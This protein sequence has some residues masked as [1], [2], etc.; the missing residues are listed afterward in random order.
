[1]T[2]PKD[3][4]KRRV[5]VDLSFGDDAVNNL[6]DRECYEGIPFR[7][8]LPTIDHVLEQ[9]LSLENPEPVKADISWAFRNVPIDPGDTIKC[10]ICHEGSY[11]VDKHLVFG[12]VNGTMIF[13]CISDAIRH[14]LSTQD[15][16]VW[17]YIDDIFAAW[18][19]EGSDEKFEALC[20]LIKELGLPLN[21]K[22]VEPPSDTMT[23]MTLGI[24]LYPYL[25]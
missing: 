13:Q 12:A 1:M 16:R 10:G 15:V 22:K 5:I 18:E 23:I 2:R 7:L 4:N 8:Q 9:I 14:M 3:I 6:T 24:A 25:P 21:D 19:S 11:Y 20:T 17:N